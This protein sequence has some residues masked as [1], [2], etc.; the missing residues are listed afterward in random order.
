MN[1]L[2]I[3]CVILGIFLSSAVAVSAIAFPLST[4]KVDQD[5]GLKL[6][7]THCKQCHGNSSEDGEKLGPS[8]LRIGSQAASRV[9]GQTAA[10]YLWESILYPDKH[11]AGEGKMPAIFG[12]ILSEKDLHDL[13]GYLGSLGSKP[14]YREILSLRKP[15]MASSEENVRVSLALEDVKEGRRLFYQKFECSKCHFVGEPYPGSD[16]LAPSLA[17]VG[18]FPREYLIQAIRN[19]SQEI[20]KAYRTAQVLTSD[21]Q[22]VTG[23]IVKKS[24]QEV[25]IISADSQ[26]NLVPGKFLLEDLEEV[27]PGEKIRYSPV[28]SMAPWSVEQMSDAEL[29]QLISFLSVLRG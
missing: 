9:E 11:S 29:D 17:A 25:T 28:S 22:L 13:V 18:L 27:S 26:G 3:R 10:G 24:D 1:S 6:F 20:H 19:P 23:R 16:L 8:L 4:A 14:D 21:G 7:S 2:A 12:S 5:H 15:Q